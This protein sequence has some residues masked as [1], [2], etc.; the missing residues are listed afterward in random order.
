MWVGVVLVVRAIDCLDSEPTVISGILKSRVSSR[1]IS[2][3]F[4]FWLQANF[5]F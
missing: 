3:F 4:F 5:F 2:F 1:G